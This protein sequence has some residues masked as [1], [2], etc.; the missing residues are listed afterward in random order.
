MPA[1]IYKINEIDKRVQVL[2]THSES[3]LYF[4]NEISKNDN[5]CRFLVCGLFG[6]ELIR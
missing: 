6:S 2:F 5:S 4:I 1:K 3:F